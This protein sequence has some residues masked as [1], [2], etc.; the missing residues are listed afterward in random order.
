MH[1][2]IQRPKSAPN[3]SNGTCATACAF[4][5]LRLAP[6][7][8]A[9]GCDTRVRARDQRASSVDNSE[10]LLCVDGTGRDRRKGEGKEGQYATELLNY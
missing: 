8:V 5:M 6:R 9:P 2:I 10:N 4:C 3:R 7:S 1:F